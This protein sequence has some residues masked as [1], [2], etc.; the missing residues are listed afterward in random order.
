VAKKIK[1]AAAN[2]KE[3][4]RERSAKEA[5]LEESFN[6]YYKHRGK[7]YRINFVRGLFFGLGAFLGGTIIITILVWI[8]SFFVNFPL[9]GELIEDT[10][11]ALEQSQQPPQQ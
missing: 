10:Q 8:M 11:K 3:A 9:I 7:V 5:L 4:A 2:D 1:T 6:D